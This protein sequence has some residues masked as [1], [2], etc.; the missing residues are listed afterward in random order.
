MEKVGLGE[1]GWKSDIYFGISINQINISGVYILISFLPERAKEKG[2]E[3]EGRRTR[4]KE[5]MI[6]IVKERKLKKLSFLKIG[7]H[8]INN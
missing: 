4:G 1:E 6:E 3:R 7:V 5:K 2:R 8:K